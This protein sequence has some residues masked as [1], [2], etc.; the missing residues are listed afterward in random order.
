MK[1]FC[2]RQDIGFSTVLLSFSRVYPRGLAGVAPSVFALA[3]ALFVDRRLVARFEK[4]ARLF[5]IDLGKDPATTSPGI[6]QLNPG[7]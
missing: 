1:R 7:V 5:R 4:G 2:V 3:L 6:E